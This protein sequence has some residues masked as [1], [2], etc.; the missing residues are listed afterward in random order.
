MAISIITSIITS[1]IIIIIIIE[2][3]IDIISRIICLLLRTP[4][5][6]GGRAARN[7]AADIPPMESEPHWSGIGTPSYPYTKA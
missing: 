5:A 3:I 6:E 4:R 2:H 7:P 1:T